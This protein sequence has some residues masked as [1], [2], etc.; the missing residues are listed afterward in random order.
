MTKKLYN[1]RIF[2]K[3]LLFWIW[4][5]LEKQL[6]SNQMSLTSTT[7]AENYKGVHLALQLV[8]QHCETPNHGLAQNL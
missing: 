7:K 6:K 4:S 1:K 8:V 3:L 2:D 5:Q